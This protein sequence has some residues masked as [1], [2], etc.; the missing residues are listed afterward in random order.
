MNH[1][2]FAALAAL[3]I[4]LFVLP[5]MATAQE[6]KKETKEK[7]EEMTK[8]HYLITLPHTPEHCLE[9]LD[10]Y[11]AESPKMLE[12]VEWACMSGDHTGYCIVK[13]ENEM[14]ARNMLP[15]SERSTAKVTKVEKFSSEQI[16]KFHEM[17]KK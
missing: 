5:N 12:K 3:V 9:M 16:K 15:A 17:M 14:E 13:A 1:R 10:S 11:S 8:A 2:F 4:V 6:M 7:K